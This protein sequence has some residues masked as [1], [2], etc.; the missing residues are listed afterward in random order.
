MRE[1]EREIG[2]RA[3]ERGTER[4]RWQVERQREGGA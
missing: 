3:K 1:K 4:E 2:A